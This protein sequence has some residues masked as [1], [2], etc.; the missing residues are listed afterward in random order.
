MKLKTKQVLLFVLL[1]L[2]LAI[3]NAQLKIPGTGNPDIR[4]ALENVISDFPKDKPS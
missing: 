1:F 3:A 2:T 4:H